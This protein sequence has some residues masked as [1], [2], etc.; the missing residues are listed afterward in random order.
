M[1]IL[2]N[3]LEWYCDRCESEVSQMTVSIVYADGTEGHVCRHH[4]GEVIKEQ[5]GE[6]VEEAC[7]I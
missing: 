6:R 5:C 4:L 7:P 2:L 3:R 1:I